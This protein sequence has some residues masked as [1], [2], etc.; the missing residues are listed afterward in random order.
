MS[1]LSDW[2]SHEKR[3]DTTVVENNNDTPPKENKKDNGV[4]VH[5]GHTYIQGVPD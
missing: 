2:A 1:Y 4:V 3:P 5:N